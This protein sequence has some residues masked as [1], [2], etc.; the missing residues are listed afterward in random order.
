MGAGYSLR[1]KSSKSK[2]STVFKGNVYFI[3]KMLLIII[4]LVTKQWLKS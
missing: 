4:K 1:I 3:I 2:R